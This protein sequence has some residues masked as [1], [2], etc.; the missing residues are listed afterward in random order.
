MYHEGVVGAKAL[1]T[2]KALKLKISTEVLVIQNMALITVQ[3]HEVHLHL[4]FVFE[5]LATLETIVNKSLPTLEF[6]LESWVL[7]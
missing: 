5:A 2:L 4:L 7:T 3:H 6:H 1:A